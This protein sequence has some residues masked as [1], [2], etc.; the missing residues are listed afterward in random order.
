[1]KVLILLSILFL[2]A[3][4]ST[5]DK[6][7]NSKLTDIIQL[8]EKAKR[9]FPEGVI[10]TF[11]IIIKATGS[12]RGAIFLNSDLDYRDPKSI[13]VVLIPSIIESF[14]KKYGSSPDTYFINKT[15]EVKGKVERVRIYMYKNERRSKK[16]YYQTQIK[17]TNITQLK[18]LS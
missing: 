15:I 8:I 7:S 9:R 16:Y 1:M 12:A 6:V 13:A 14:T 2:S 4:S 18:V 11:Q 17:V 3:C 5:P 10:G